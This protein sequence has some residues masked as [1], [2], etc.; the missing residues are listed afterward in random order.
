MVRAAW[1]RLRT[2]AP[3]CPRFSSGWA[4]RQTA[5]EAAGCHDHHSCADEGQSGS[6]WWRP[7]VGPAFLE[8]DRRFGQG[9]SPASPSDLSTS[10]IDNLHNFKG[11]SSC[12][13]QDRAAASGCNTP[14]ASGLRPAGFYQ[15]EQYPKF[16]N[17]PS[18]VRKLG[19]LDR[20]KPFC[21]TKCHR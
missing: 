16:I 6:L 5:F 4:K 2:E 13:S 19:L 3:K 15:A 20:A 21:E 18:F 14:V 9:R 11:A 1:S 8:C 10:A 7:V 12:A 17:Q